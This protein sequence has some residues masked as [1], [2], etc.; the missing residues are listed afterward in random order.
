MSSW[1]AAA[2]VMLGSAAGGVARYL[3][4]R[5]L[6]PRWTGAFPLATLTVNLSK[7]L[8]I[9]GLMA[10]PTTGAGIIMNPSLQLF[11]ALGFL[12]S[13]TTV[14]SFSLQ[15][16]ELMQ[17]GRFWRA[18]SYASASVLGCLAAAALGWCA[19]RILLA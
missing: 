18:W 12:G 1:T 15:M 16:F 3:V 14:S 2:I 4:S 8:A 6:E 5:L 19:I 11:L 13:Y 9:G 7:S 10:L 17:H